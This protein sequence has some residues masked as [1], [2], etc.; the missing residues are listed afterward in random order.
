MIDIISP[1]AIGYDSS[2]H[3]HKL[4]ALMTLT[5]IIY[6][7]FYKKKN[8][9]FHYL[10]R[11]STVIIFSVFIYILKNGNKNVQK[12]FY[13]PNVSLSYR[14][15]ILILTNSTERNT[16]K[17]RPQF[18]TRYSYVVG[19][20]GTVVVCPSVCLSVCHKCIVAKRC[21]IEPR[22]LLITNRKSHTPLQM[23]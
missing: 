1:A 2:C 11:Y 18:L 19:V 20:H 10:P 12:F 6:K 17:V 21:E 7:V 3:F 23:R 13:A 15:K 5:T 8:N 22:L 16:A 4:F 14:V 9:R